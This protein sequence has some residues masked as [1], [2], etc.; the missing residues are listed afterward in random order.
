MSNTGTAVDIG[1]AEKVGQPTDSPK[2]G[3]T[4]RPPS[5]QP[6]PLNVDALVERIGAAESTMAARFQTLDKVASNVGNLKSDVNGLKVEMDTIKSE[7]AGLSNPNTET[8]LKVAELVGKVAKHEETLRAQAARMTKSGIP[9]DGTEDPASSF[10]T[11]KQYLEMG[12][13][14]EEVEKLVAKVTAIE[15]VLKKFIQVEEDIKA[16][17]KTADEAM[18]KA[19]AGV[20]ST[21]LATKLAGLATLDALTALATLDALNAMQAELNAEKAKVAAMQGQIVADPTVKQLMRTNLGWGV[22]LGH[23]TGAAL[24]VAAFQA[25]ARWGIPM[26]KP[27]WMGLE[28]NVWANVGALAVGAGGAHWSMQ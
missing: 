17:K 12:T 19:N 1:H 20:N 23:I 21:D 16:I 28:T 9:K 18:E 14:V 27:E 10:V 6:R 15:E 8:E 26:V 3:P 2:P 25:V 22:K 7:I 11:G 4:T 13:R 24:G 5:P